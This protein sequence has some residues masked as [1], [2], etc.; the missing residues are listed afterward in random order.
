MSIARIIEDIK[1]IN[2]LLD[3]KGQKWAAEEKER[4]ENESQEKARPVRRK[5][6]HGVCRGI[7]RPFKPDTKGENS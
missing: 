2:R 3:P 5:T 4:R 6:L 7:P 1:S